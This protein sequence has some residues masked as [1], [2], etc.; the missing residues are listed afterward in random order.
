VACNLCDLMSASETARK[1]PDTSADISGESIYET[2]SARLA[3]MHKFLADVGA[4][5]VLPR[6]ACRQVWDELDRV[7]DSVSSAVAKRLQIEASGG[8]PLAVCFGRRMRRVREMQQ[9]VGTELAHMSFGDGCGVIFA[10]SAARFSRYCPD[11]R[12]KPGGRLRAE[13]LARA[14]AAS[15]G[16]FLLHGGW[17]VTCSGCGER[18]STASPRRRRCDNCRH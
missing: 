14:I 2:A 3:S 8:R 7:R 5:T 9:F 6:S 17:R 16:R 13:I 15:E 12:K 10:D 18:F 4:G 11:C 1:A